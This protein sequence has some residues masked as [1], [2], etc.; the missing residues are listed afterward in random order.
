VALRGGLLDFQ[1]VAAEVG[2]VE[3]F[4]DSA[5]VGVRARAHATVT[6]R[7][8]GCKLGHQ[9]TLLIEQLIRPVGAHPLL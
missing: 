2:Q 1:C 7:G 8:E 9:A 4:E 6:C 3:V 5:A